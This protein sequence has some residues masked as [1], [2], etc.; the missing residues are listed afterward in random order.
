MAA[1]LGNWCALDPQR[2]DETGAQKVTIVEIDPD[3]SG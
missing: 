1:L 3:M 2:E